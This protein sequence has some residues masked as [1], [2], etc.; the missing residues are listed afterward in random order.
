MPNP[1][2]GNRSRPPR[3]RTK[4]SPGVG[5]ESSWPSGPGATKGLSSED[6]SRGSLNVRQDRHAYPV[7]RAGYAFFLT[8]KVPTG[9]FNGDAPLWGGRESFRETGKRGNVA[10]GHKSREV[11]V[12]LSETEPFLSARTALLLPTRRWH[13]YRQPSGHCVA[14]S[15][16]AV[17]GSEHALTSSGVGTGSGRSVGRPLTPGGAASPP[18]R[19]LSEAVRSRPADTRLWVKG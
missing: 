14:E 17:L 11:F 1:F 10:T 9:D 12:K 13:V 6:I 7:G 19:S 15:A 18:P 3:G 16:A 4:G 8:K 2:P 5:G